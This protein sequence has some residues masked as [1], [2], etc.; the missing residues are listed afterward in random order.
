M[1][2]ERGVTKLGTL[3]GIVM[4][5]TLILFIAVVC[6]KFSGEKED[7]TVTNT[8]V[9]N[10]TTMENT[11]TNQVTE[12][13]VISTGNSEFDYKFLKMENNK[14]NML[15][16]PLSI[17]YALKMLQ[18]G[19][20]GNT[21]AQI[22]NV[23][24]NL[25]LPAYKNIPSTLSLANGIFIRDTFYNDVKQ[26]YKNVLASRYNAEINQDSFVN[27]N[28]INSW[29]ENKTLGIIKNMLNDS[30]VT[31]PEM[32]MAL[33]NA[34]AIDME[35]KNQFA[36]KDT[37]GQTFNLSDGNQMQATMMH[38]EIKD[39]SASYYVGNDVTALSMDLKQYDGQQ[40][41][42]VAIMPKSNL[43]QYVSSLTVDKIKQIDNNLKKASNESAGIRVSIPKF[44]FEYD[45][46]LKKDLM[47]LGITDA[48]SRG[49]ANFSKMSDKQLYVSEALHKANID[50]TE[51]GV[52]AAAVT[53][54]L[55]MENAAMIEEEQPV[56]VTIDNPFMFLIRD[57]NTKEI[58]FTGTV[59]EPNSWEKDQN[60]YRGQY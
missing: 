48:F 32:R 19:A 49:S 58:W 38:N 12:Q 31:D 6:L 52:K 35:W 44:S 43:D 2:D 47:N 8:A 18:E 26:E 55:M 1:R 50:F 16:S 23:V 24:G 21:Y 36:D 13:P 51:K 40:L 4:L 53:V 10:T 57:K 28:N 14:N 15:Y 17:K 39:D 60:E 9:T 25:N 46:E 7:N 11:T 33:I 54:F 42:F 41:E 30:Q 56:E 20:D 34:L 27:A 59:Y 22:N 5:L 3:I 29:I 45:L 37:H